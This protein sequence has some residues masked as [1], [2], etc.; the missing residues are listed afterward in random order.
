MPFLVDRPWTD[1]WIPPGKTSKQ[2][3]VY[4]QY[5]DFGPGVVWVN[6]STDGGKTF[7]TPVNVINSPTALAA[8]ACNAMPGGVKVVQSGSRA[9][10]VYVAWLASDDAQNGATGCNETQLAGFH[11]MWVAWSDDGGATWT[12]QLVYDGGIGRD[13]SEFWP[14]ITLDNK[15]NPYVS[16]SM[17]IGAEFDI[18]VEAS[19]DGGKSWNGKTD[20]TGKPFRANVG[21]GTHYFPAIAAGAPGKIAVAYLGTKTIVGTRPNGKPDPTTDTK[22]SWNAFVSESVNLRTKKPTFSEAKVS[23][24]PMHVGDVCTLGL[25]CAAVPGTDRSLLDFIDVQVDPSGHAHIVY[26]D[27]HNYKNG[28]ATV[29][30]NQTSGPNLGRGGH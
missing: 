26:A 8:S 11:S 16:F 4:V 5:H 9:G 6:S 21:K 23:P 14:D 20:G 28:G 17:N 24:K 10:R 3:R 27:N 12:D 25:F 30:G 18:W 13:G 15:G 19:Y 29:A 2:S 1:A 7:S 22:S